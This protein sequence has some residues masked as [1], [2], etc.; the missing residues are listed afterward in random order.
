MQ[1]R[2]DILSNLEKTIAQAE[3]NPLYDMGMQELTELIQPILSLQIQ[4][5]G[6]YDMLFTA[7]H[8]AFKYGYV[9][10][11]RATLAELKK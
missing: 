4:T 9:K 10:G 11:K 6:L 2:G 8:S 1:E 5:P 3:L 7:I